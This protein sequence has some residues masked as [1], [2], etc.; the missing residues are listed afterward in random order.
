MRTCH[1]C[2]AEA[3][4]GKKTGRRDECPRCHA[5]LHCCLNCRF[6]D[7]AASRQC[8]EPVVELVKVKDRANFCDFF[9]FSDRQGA[10]PQDSKAGAARAALDGLFKK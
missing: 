2:G 5:D 6:H 1:A 7:A 8:R 9:E 3:G 10:G 4:A